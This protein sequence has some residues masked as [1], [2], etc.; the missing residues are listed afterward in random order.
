MTNSLKMLDA[1]I[2]RFVSLV[3]FVG[4]V[5]NTLCPKLVSVEYECDEYHE[6]LANVWLPQKIP[7]AIGKS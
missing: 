3:R 2:T 7:D 4:F 1:V 6:C 5:M